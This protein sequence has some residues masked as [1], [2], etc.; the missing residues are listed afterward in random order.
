M[1]KLLELDPARWPFG[2]RNFMAYE[3]ISRFFNSQD[4]GPGKFGLTG[5]FGQPDYCIHC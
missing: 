3:G 5:G 1:M 2:Q 4:R